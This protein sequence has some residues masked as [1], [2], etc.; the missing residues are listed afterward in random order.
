M[1][2]VHGLTQAGPV[3]VAAFTLNPPPADIGICEKKNKQPLLQ[4]RE[5]QGC[6]VCVR[7]RDDKPVMKAGIGKTFKAPAFRSAPV[8]LLPSGAFC[9]EIASKHKSKPKRWEMKREL[10]G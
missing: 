2:F 6:C 10:A 9:S 1:P 7:T 3:L 8:S 5:I 4:Q